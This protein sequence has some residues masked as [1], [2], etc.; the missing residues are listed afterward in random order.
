MTT[1]VVAASLHQKS[2]HDNNEKSGESDIGMND[3]DD[4][5]SNGGEL[6][7]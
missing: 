2:G 3:G 4:G 5:T 1:R 7:Y 6:S